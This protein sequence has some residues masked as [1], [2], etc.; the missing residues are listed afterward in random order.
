[1]FEPKEQP[2]ISTNVGD[3]KFTDRT[4]SSTSITFG[5]ISFALGLAIA[6]GGLVAAIVKAS[7]KLSS[8]K[9]DFEMM[10]VKINQKIDVLDT[11]VKQKLE[12][13]D[14]GVNQK[15]DALKATM[16]SGFEHTRAEMA[17]W[18]VRI[19]YNSSKI[20]DVELYLHKNGFVIRN[21]QDDSI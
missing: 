2:K 17:Q 4:L 21:N 12:N 14:A 13:L 1:M 10:D 3:V 7:L 15:T 6:F 5:D 16:T 18:R 11:V 19:N 20:R 8:L 9:N